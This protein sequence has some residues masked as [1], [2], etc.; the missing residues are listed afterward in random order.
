M[1]LQLH[2]KR[3]L[4]P[5]K[6]SRSAQVAEHTGRG[7]RSSTVTRTLPPRQLNETPGTPKMS[8][9]HRER[10]AGH[11]GEEGV[12]SKRRGAPQRRLAFTR[13]GLQEIWAPTGCAQGSIVRGLSNPHLC[14]HCRKGASKAMPRSTQACMPK[15]RL[16]EVKR[17]SCRSIVP[18]GVTRLPRRMRA[19]FAL[20]LCRYLRF[21]RTVR[22]QTRGCV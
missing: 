14:W 17:G 13:Y 16:V 18:L 15:S 2:V 10:P 4:V 6:S 8:I 19:A 3:C 5:L 12:Y 11:R 1:Y 9:G 7:V 22:R 21:R 20:V